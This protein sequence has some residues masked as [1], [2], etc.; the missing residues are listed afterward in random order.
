MAAAAA[1][2]Q[3]RL[4]KAKAA[5]EGHEDG[6]RSELLEREGKVG[7]CKLNSAWP[8]ALKRLVTQP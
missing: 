1:E 2:F 6:R 8:I 3:Q 5:A 4:N 7:R